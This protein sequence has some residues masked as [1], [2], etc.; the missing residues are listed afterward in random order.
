MQKG[1][2]DMK[3]AMLKVILGVCMTA[4]LLSGCGKPEGAKQNAVETDLEVQQDAEL[5]DDSS[6]HSNDKLPFLIHRKTKM[7]PAKK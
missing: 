4:V 7:F 5:A 3:N 2:C 1:D 6:E